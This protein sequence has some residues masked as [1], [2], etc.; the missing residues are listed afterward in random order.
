MGA[1]GPGDAWTVPALRAEIEAFLAAW[2][3]LAL[4]TVAEDGSAHAASLLYAP[5]GLGL[6][7]TS[8]PRSRHSQYLDARPRVTATVAPDYSD[9]AAIR[10]LQMAGEA[11]RLSGP[12]E[13]ARAG[14]LLT[15]RY[16][17]L[18]KLSGA[19]AVLRAA[20]DK[21]SFYRFKP[22]RITLID[23]TRGFGHKATLLVAADGTL[24]LG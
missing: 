16:L 3:T 17:F 2:H 14:A 9:F 8:D 23:N 21:A 22:S 12:M 5:D 24:A 6:V 1:T 10:G 4:A 20:W 7:W 18:A 15:T 11:V 19:P 13:M